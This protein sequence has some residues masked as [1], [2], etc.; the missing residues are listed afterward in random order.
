M[1]DLILQLITVA[2]VANIVLIIAALVIPRL[3]RPQ[4]PAA[5]S[6]APTVGGRSAMTAARPPEASEARSGQN[7]SGRDTDVEGDAAKAME[8]D[9]TQRTRRFAL[10]SDDDYPTTASVEAFLS[11]GR[12]E[13]PLDEE[14]LVD[15]ETGLETSLA[16][17]LAISREEARLARYGR[18][19]TIVIAELDRLEA[20][21]AR[22]GQESAD[23]LVPPVAKTFRRYARAADLVARTGRIRF[24]VLMP[25][26]DEVQ[27]I[28]YVERVREA[29]DMWL[30]ASAVSVRLTI[31]WSSA[32]AGG[33]LRDAV[34]LAAQRMHAD[35][36]RGQGG[37][38]GAGPIPG[39]A[40]APAPERPTPDAPSPSA[41]SS[42]P[43]PAAPAPP[44]PEPPQASHDPGQ[45]GPYPPRPSS[46]PTI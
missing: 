11:G 3:R 38:G 44:A 2:V 13:P 21:A 12:R 7:R 41:G 35:R 15:E 28:N 40:D 14:S 17:E 46:G 18:P 25:E 10:P 27:A 36:A 24:Q 31:G 26:T 33:S 4:Q 9:E 29:C 42:S 1:N 8:P 37:R 32:G 5:S 34:R 45:P 43:G 23:R 39:V 20:L 22:L 6:A 19:V 30:E 16:W